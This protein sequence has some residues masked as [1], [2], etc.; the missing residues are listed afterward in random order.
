[1]TETTERLD[2]VGLYLDTKY[3]VIRC[4]TCGCP[5]QI[6]TCSNTS[7]DKGN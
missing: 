5:Y 6:C 4:K 7:G 1:M 2:Q 3:N